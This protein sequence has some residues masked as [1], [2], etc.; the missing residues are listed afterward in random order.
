M[1]DHDLWATVDGL[2][3]ETLLDDEPVLQ[4]VLE[5]GRQANLPQIQ[6]SAPQAKLLY[7]LARAI[8]AERIL[9]VGTLAGYSGIWLARA[10]PEGGRLVTIEVDPGHAAVASAN[11][12]AAGVADKVLL[13]TGAALDVLAEIEAE[14]LGPFDLTFIDADKPN[15]SNYL[16]WATKL[17]RPGSV[18]VLDNVVRGGAVL[19]REVDAN[20]AGAHDA[21]A[22]LGDRP[23]LDSTVIQTVGSKGYDGFAISVVG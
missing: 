22:W 10:L 15:N 3:E 6:V 5:R 13:R 23:G 2:I 17:S 4:E 18:I 19:D 8:R 21:L 16:E 9:E 7:L 1:S 14:G 20:A 12:V 11:F